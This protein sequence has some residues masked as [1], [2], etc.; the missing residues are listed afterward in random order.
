MMVGC[1]GLDVAGCTG[2]VVVIVEPGLGTDLELDGVAAAVFGYMVD[3]VGDQ[4]QV[5]Q[6]PR[7]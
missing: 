1:A 7:G 5:G 4:Q 3:E 2:L 6:G